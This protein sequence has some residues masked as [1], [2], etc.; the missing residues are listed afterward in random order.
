[1]T[2]RK[3]T[4]LAWAIGV[5]SI[6]ALVVVNAAL[7]STDLEALEHVGRDGSYEVYRGSWHFPRGGP[8]VLGFDVAGDSEL[9]IDG[10]VV[11]QGR[12]Q[13]A[14]R[15]VYPPGVV[16][17]EVRAGE[18]LRLL[19]HPP[20]RRG[21]LEYVM[22][23]S[24]SSQPAAAASFDDGAGRAL[25]DGLVALLAFAVLIGLLLFTA[26]RRLVTVPRQAW[27]GF[28]GV[29]VV[30]AAARL[31]DLDG[32]GQTWDEDVNWSAGRN[33]LV[34]LLS[35]DFARES[36]RWN[37]EHPPLMKYL[38]GIGALFGE[39][40]GPARAISALVV[41]VSC[42]WLVLVV[43]RL[44]DLPTGIIAGLIAALSP[45]LIAHG[46]VV[47]HEALTILW[48]TIAVWAALE[49]AD[50]DSRKIL[51]RRLLVLG[52]VVGAAVFSRF[53]NVLMAP[54]IAGIVLV[55]TPAERRRD[56]VLIGLAVVP[57][58]ALIFGYLMW[59]RLWTAPIASLQEAWIKL[60]KPHSPELY[61]G[62]M[63]NV[64]ARHYFLVYLGATAPLG[65]LLASL[66]GLV[67][68]AIRRRGSDLV[69]LLWLLC[70]LAVALSP[71]RQDGV[72]YIM[73]SLVAMAVL[74]AVGLRELS[75]LLGRWLPQRIGGPAVAAVMAVYLLVVCW[76]INPYYLDYY[77]EHVGG[78]A[79]VHQRKSFELAWWGE[80]LDRAIDYLNEH[81][82]PNA[83]VYKACVVPSHLT[84][85]RHDLWAREARRPERADWLL[86]YQ[87]YTGRCRVPDDARLVFEVEAMGAPLA[88]V[89]KR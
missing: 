54:M 68:A 28:F 29:L 75:A 60:R 20:G 46:K 69:V 42:G 36:W 71:V 32:A 11:A 58:V 24:L 85:M 40:Y 2:A 88:R 56:A 15:L 45:H 63:S 81:A 30:A 14:K 6:V 1:M 66:G 52:L 16:D 35:L 33:Y 12:G 5:A 18:Q 86:V 73:P 84:W 39:G 64:P 41:A 37:Y 77:G 9:L 89:Y 62:A 82:E 22:P 72:R 38:A 83:S 34:N 19:W 21:P 76:R 47:G 67:A 51:M 4:A 8:Y 79:G 3:Q 61:L 31:I 27:L 23:S 57:I 43:R 10:E 80:G 7:R 87:P 44:F 25:G 70:P 49:V 74:A 78:P 59:P 17:V 55:K 26:R 48:W 13:V 50:A 53:V 65:V